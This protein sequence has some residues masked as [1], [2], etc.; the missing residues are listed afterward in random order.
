[1]KEKYICLDIGN[2]IFH[3]NEKGFLDHLDE[4][5]KLNLINDPLGK[6]TNPKNIN[7]LW[8]MKHSQALVDLGLSSIK[9]ELLDHYDW[10]LENSLSIWDS[11]LTPCYETINFIND[12]IKNRFNIAL[13]SNIGY[14]H[15]KLIRNTLSYLL[16]CSYSD[17]GMDGI[18]THFSCEVGAR[19]PQKLYYQ[20]FLMLHPEFEECYFVDDRQENLDAAGEFGFTPHLF[21]ISKGD[22]EYQINILE[23]NIGLDRSNNCWNRIIW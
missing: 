22:V 23:N 2:V 4:L 10:Q 17:N 16:K 9:D 21:D 12:L 20:S 15:A 11:I 5:Y 8:F 13:V 6:A 1:M 3:I 18:I 19:K 14:E 7:S